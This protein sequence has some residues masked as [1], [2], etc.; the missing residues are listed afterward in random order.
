MTKICNGC[1]IEKLLAEFSFR[2]SGKS[3]GKPYPRCRECCRQYHRITRKENPESHR[4]EVRKWRRDNPDLR[5]ASD[6]R[7]ENSRR[8]RDPNWRSKKNVRA[9][10]YYHLKGGKSKRTAEY[11]GCSLSAFREHL[12]ALF[13]PGMSWR[14]QELWEMDHIKPCASFDLSDPAQQAACFHWSNWQPLWADD[15]MQKSDRLDWHPAESQ[16]SLPARLALKPW[17]CEGLGKLT[18]RL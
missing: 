11:L 6:R 1:R 18:L 3:A 14:N 9:L 13:W 10:L 7:Y 5:R 15:N 12:E 4:V 16:H 2:H 8:K 17:D